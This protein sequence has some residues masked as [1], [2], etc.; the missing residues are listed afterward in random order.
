MVFCKDLSDGHE[1]VPV[2]VVI[3]Q[4][5]SLLAAYERSGSDAATASRAKRPIVP[6]VVPAHFK[7]EA[8]AYTH[9]TQSARNY[10]DHLYRPARAAGA[11]VGAA[12][13]DMWSGCQHTDVSKKRL[14]RARKSRKASKWAAHAPLRALHACTH[15]PILE[16]A[17]DCTCPVRGCAT[18]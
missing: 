3:D 13:A 6:R 4:P 9:V 7:W 5:A 11:S 2:R 8:R 18:A 14:Q 15:T 10:L 17:P 16:C 12:P 1:S